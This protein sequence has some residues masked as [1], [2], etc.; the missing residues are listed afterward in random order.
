MKLK[1][2]E[3]LENVRENVINSDRFGNAVYAE[4]IDGN[5]G[6]FVVFE[7]YTWVN[8]NYMSVSIVAYQ[9]NGYTEFHFVPAG[10]GGGYLNIDWGSKDRRVGKLFGLLGTLDYHYEEME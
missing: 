6:L 7:N 9:K 10:S 5:K 1:I 3:S 2:Y 4:W 8:K